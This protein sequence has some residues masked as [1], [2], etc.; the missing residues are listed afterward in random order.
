MSKQTKIIIGVIAGIAILCL[1]AC[2]VGFLLFRNFSTQVAS[3]IEESSNDPESV[4]ANAAAMAEFTLPSGFEP[5]G[6]MDIF[7]M[8]MAMYT[9]SSNNHFLSMIQMPGITEMN[10]ETIRQMREGM[11]RGSSRGLQNLRII[12]TREM[13]IRGEPAQ[14]IL[15]EGTDDGSNVRQLMVVFEGKGGMTMMMIVGD[16]NTWDQA[17]YDNMVNSIH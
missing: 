3:Q 15:Q 9:N 7:G 16:A 10:E 4:N 14:M 13:T 2:G 8:K 12:E 1:I 11:E 17:A 5:Q 6:S